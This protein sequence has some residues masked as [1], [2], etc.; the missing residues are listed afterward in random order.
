MASIKSNSETS[1]TKSTPRS[2]AAPQSTP[3]AT[4]EEKTPEAT[5]EEKT[6]GN[7]LP[8]VYDDKGD[9][10][11]EFALAIQ[12]LNAVLECSSGLTRHADMN[13]FGSLP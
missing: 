5:P 13:F 2:S 9:V 7:T 1:T 3:E 12:A 10:S 4:P 11:A 8:D 6:R